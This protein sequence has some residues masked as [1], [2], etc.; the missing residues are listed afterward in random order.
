MPNIYV[1]DFTDPSTAG[2]TIKPGQLDG[3]TGTV[4][5]TD[6]RLY[7]EGHLQWGEGVHENFV[8]ILENFA[9]PDAAGSTNSNPLPENITNPITGQLWYSKDRKKIHY[10]NGTKWVALSKEAQQG[11]TAPTDPSE[12]DF[13]WDIDA[14]ERNLYIYIDGQWRRI[15]ADYL[16]RDGTK[17]MAGILN[18]D[19]HRIT[20][21]SAPTNNNDAVN[22]TYVDTADQALQAEIDTKVERAGDTMTGTLIIQNGALAVRTIAGQYINGTPGVATTFET[23][24]ATC[25]RIKCTAP[26]GDGSPSPGITIYNPDNDPLVGGAGGTRGWTVLTPR[27]GSVLQIEA[28]DEDVGTNWQGSHNVVCTMGEYTNGNMV[29]LGLPGNTLGTAQN[30]IRVPNATFSSSDS[31]VTKQYVDVIG[32]NLTNNYWTRTQ[33]D[34]RY[35]NISGDQMTGYLFLVSDPTN[36]LHAATKRY[37]DNNVSPKVNRAGDTMTSFLS[38]HAN[39]TANMHAATKQYVD[40]TIA[41]SIPPAS[42]AGVGSGQIWYNMTYAR[43]GNVVYQNTLSAPICVQMTLRVATGRVGYFLVG[44]SNPPTM[45]MWAWDVDSGGSWDQTWLS[46][47]VPPYWYYYF[48]NSNPLVDFG[49][50]ETQWYELR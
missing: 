11:T 28:N 2:F 24:A 4:A 49:H 16:L 39:P 40:N 43:T 50:A 35:V 21:V 3:P 19:S 44:P 33:A 38:L 25:L 48:D 5:H 8:H 32:N 15:V 47:I 20:N 1:I 42:P 45:R 37:V 41:S 23:P 22:K 26:A 7:G 34:D 6:L 13:W 17:P 36:E 18:M 31:V 27:D 46:C 12:G 14:G 10:Y 29:Y 9:C 30:D